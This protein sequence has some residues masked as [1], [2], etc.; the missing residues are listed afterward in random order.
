M[1]KEVRKQS[2]FSFLVFGEVDNLKEKNRIMYN[3][4]IVGVFME[5]L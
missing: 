5:F 3:N 2:A 1:K 4:K